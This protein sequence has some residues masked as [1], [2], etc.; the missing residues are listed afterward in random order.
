MHK[1]LWDSVDPYHVHLVA[2]SLKACL[3]TLTTAT[4]FEP[5]NP[6]LGDV[7]CWFTSPWMLESLLGLR[8]ARFT[9][10]D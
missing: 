5:P 4:L 6:N 1:I 9:I 7:E 2:A 10:H 8:M 3:K